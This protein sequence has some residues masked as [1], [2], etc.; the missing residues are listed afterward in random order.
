MYILT[1]YLGYFLNGKPKIVF[2]KFKN[3]LKQPR[4]AK[5][6]NG[7]EGRKYKKIFKSQG[8]LHYR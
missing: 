5:R 4:S 8:T 7:R 1:Q 3:I 6:A 2:V